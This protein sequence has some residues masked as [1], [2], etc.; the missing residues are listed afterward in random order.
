MTFFWKAVYEEEILLKFKYL[1]LMIPNTVAFCC[2]RVFQ[3]RPDSVC[4]Y[5][6]FTAPCLMQMYFV[7]NRVSKTLYPG[8]CVFH[9]PLERRLGYFLFSFLLPWNCHSQA[10]GYFFA[11]GSKYQTLAC[12]SVSRKAERWKK[13]MEC[14]CC[15]STQRKE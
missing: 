8:F 14:H 13:E 7:S 3:T 6:S 11:I 9:C 12:H 1:T 2:S 4:P 5:N 10:L 15:S